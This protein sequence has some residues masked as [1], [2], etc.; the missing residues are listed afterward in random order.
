VAA[1]IA[2]GT[3]VNARDNEGKTALAYARE[4]AANYPEYDM[5]EVYRIFEAAGAVE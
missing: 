3:E 4:H 2:G 5:G 1:L